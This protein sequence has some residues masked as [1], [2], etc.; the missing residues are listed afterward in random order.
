MK[1]HTYIL[2]RRIPELVHKPGYCYALIS[3]WK[4]LKIID[5]HD[6]HDRSLF[7]NSLTSLA[8][9]VLAHPFLN[10]TTAMQFI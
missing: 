6:Y 1:G 7:Y 8:D 4:C 9:T 5:Q 2:S 3:I 10:K